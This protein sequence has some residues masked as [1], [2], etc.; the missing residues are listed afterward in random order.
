[1]KMGPNKTI[2]KNFLKKLGS[3]NKDYVV[4]EQMGVDGK[5][6]SDGAISRFVSGY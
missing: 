5:I 2:S 4:Q 1:M 6:L 3:L